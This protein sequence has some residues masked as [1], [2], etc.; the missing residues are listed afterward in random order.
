MGQKREALDQRVMWNPCLGPE[1]GAGNQHF[2]HGSSDIPLFTCRQRSALFPEF[3]LPETFTARQ[4][5]IVGA[6]WDR[7]QLGST[8]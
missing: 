8:T 6:P 3:Q 4:I 2:L 7:T 1:A 5:E